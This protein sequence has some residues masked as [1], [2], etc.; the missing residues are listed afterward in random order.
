MKEKREES[1]AAKASAQTGTGGNANAATYSEQQGN[2]AGS[3]MHTFGRH[4]AKK[5]Q[6][7]ANFQSEL[8]LCINFPRRIQHLGSMCSNKAMRRL[9]R[10]SWVNNM[11]RPHWTNEDSIPKAGTAAENLP[12]G[13]PHSGISKHADS[14][15]H[16]MAA[17]D[18]TPPSSPPASPLARP[19]SPEYRV[20]TPSYSR[21]QTPEGTEED[22]Q[23]VAALP[24]QPYSPT[25]NMPLSY[26]DSRA[27]AYKSL[28]PGRYEPSRPGCLVIPADEGAT[29]DNINCPSD[30]PYS[31]AVPSPGTPLVTCLLGVSV[32]PALLHCI[33]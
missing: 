25:A 33:S 31:P 2:A 3:N 8:D 16:E 12:M 7:P 13:S 5:H 11:P 14:Q 32:S 30:A 1:Q 23:Y 4:N 20:T 15:A 6:M 29:G 24:Y 28:S 9:G 19:V 10:L 21:C 22:A 26:D 27:A 17:K 18:V